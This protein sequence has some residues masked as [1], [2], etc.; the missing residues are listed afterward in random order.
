MIM[1]GVKK[2]GR[3]GLKL[4]RDERGSFDQL[5]WAIGAAVVVVAII[6]VLRAVAPDT[7]SN[8]WSAA[9][10]WIRSSFGF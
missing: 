6:L 10:S 5:V 7:V 4:I 8:L 9:T 1:A 3:L 2:I